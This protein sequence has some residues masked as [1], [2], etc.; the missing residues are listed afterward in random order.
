MTIDQPV[1]GAVAPEEVPTKYLQA[2][3]GT[4]DGGEGGGRR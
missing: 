4:A 2:V 3:R 1:R